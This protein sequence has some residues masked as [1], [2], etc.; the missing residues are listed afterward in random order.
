MKK[1]TLSDKDLVITILSTAFDKS[2]SINYITKQDRLRSERIKKLMEYSFDMCFTFGEIWMNEDENAC[3]LL[4]HPDKKRTTLRS[5]FWHAKLVMKVIGLT[6]IPAVLKREFFIKRKHPK[7][8]SFCYLWFIGVNPA[9]H[10]KGIG[11][12]LLQ[13]VMRYCDENRRPIYLETSIEENLSWYRKNGFEIFHSIDLSYKLH[14]LRRIKT[15][16]NHPHLIEDTKM[17]T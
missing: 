6:Q 10:N 4:L 13:D 15:L 9:E 14:L 1:V 11:T 12:K 16:K 17:H 3:A 7:Y 8:S 2:K 5:I